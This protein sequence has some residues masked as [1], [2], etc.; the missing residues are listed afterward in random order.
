[1][2]AI[3]E[4]KAVRQMKE[5]YKMIEDAKASMQKGGGKRKKGGRRHKKLGIK[6]NELEKKINKLGIRITKNLS[7][8]HNVDQYLDD[9]GADISTN[10]DDIGIIKSFINHKMHQIHTPSGKTVLDKWNNHLNNINR[11][12]SESAMDQAIMRDRLGI[13]GGRRKTRKRRRKNKK[14]RRKRRRNKKTR[15]KK[16]RK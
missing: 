1:M 10:A 9:F 12:D 2:P 4:V 11:G 6:I 16:S 8:I 13:N 5:Y 15:R 3:P 14:T 7:M